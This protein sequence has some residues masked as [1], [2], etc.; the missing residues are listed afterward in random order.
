[1]T[2]TI[3]GRYDAKG[4]AT[5]T[6]SAGTVQDAA[7]ATASGGLTLVAPGESSTAE[8]NGDA[9]ATKDWSEQPV[10]DDETALDLFLSMMQ[11]PDSALPLIIIGAGVGLLL[12]SLL[13]L[14]VRRAFAKKH[15]TGS[16]NTLPPTTGGLGGG[17]TQSTAPQAVS[18]LTT[19]RA[20]VAQGAAHQQPQYVPQVQANNYMAPGAPSTPAGQQHQQAAGSSMLERMKAKGI[21]VP[22]STNQPTNQ[23]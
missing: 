23:P 10:T 1:M 20:V 9:G 8:S 15:G 12:I 5:A 13:L 14:L 11:S 2:K 6:T 4:G 22:T 18:P 21:T 7:D 3:S 19:A 17:S 16:G